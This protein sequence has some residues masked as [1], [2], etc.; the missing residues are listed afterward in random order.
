MPSI[1]SE[2]DRLLDE[3]D[4]RAAEAVRRSRLSRGVFES[5]RRRQLDNPASLHPLRRQR[6][7]FLGGLTVNELSERALVGASTIHDL[8][9]GKPGS[10][11]TWER[12]ARALGGID[13]RRI[14]PRYVYTG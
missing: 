13:R 1:E 8:E 4:F 14:D 10:D 5:H 6:L 7:A 11:L 3:A 12:L 9:K 2:L